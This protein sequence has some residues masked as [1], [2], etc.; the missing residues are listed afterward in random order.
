MNQKKH[1]F[2]MLFRAVA[3]GLFTAACSVLLL[4]GLFYYYTGTPV[5][6]IKFFRTLH[7]V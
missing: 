1:M 4:V 6:F 5:G 2:Q 7:V 3:W